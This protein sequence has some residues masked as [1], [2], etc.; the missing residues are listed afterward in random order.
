[1]FCV[2]AR[3]CCVIAKVL[4]M[5]F[6]VALWFLRFRSVFMVLLDGAIGYFGGL[7]GVALMVCKHDLCPSI[8]IH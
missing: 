3:R 1:M 8:F 7:L 6:I 2:V 4:R 5:V